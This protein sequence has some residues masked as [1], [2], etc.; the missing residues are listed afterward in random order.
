MMEN[1]KYSE[2]MGYEGG[3]DMDARL[4]KCEKMIKKLAE[5]VEMPMDKE[6]EESEE[7]H[8]MKKEGEEKPSVAILMKK[9]N[10]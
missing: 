1:E 8:G 7:V 5:Y 6:Y 4:S 9:E 3:K 10:L 2:D